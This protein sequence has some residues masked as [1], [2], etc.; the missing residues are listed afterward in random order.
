MRQDLAPY[1]QLGQDAVNPLWSAMGYQKGA[2]GSMQ[3]NPNS[4][5]QS[6]FAFDPNN[7][8]NTPGYQFSLQQG[9]RGTNNSLA[10]Q[11]LG[12]SG[13]QAK[14]LSSFAT[15]L[16]NQTYGDQYNRALSTY[17]TNYQ[18][19]A[20]NVNNLQNLVNT[21]QNSAAQTGQAGIAS[22][23]NAGNYLTQAGNAQASGIM[24]AANAA[25]SG[26]NNYM[27]YNAL[28]KNGSS[29]S[30]GSAVGNYLTS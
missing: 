30:F 6:Q 24:G 12:L 2:D 11:G 22:A 14:G 8:E 7:L 19:A 27:L 26:A 25:S 20:N 21:G 13:A 1:N 23:N 9:L 3:I 16:A 17:N 5:L 4:T 28:Y 29:P 15:G 18:V 10:A